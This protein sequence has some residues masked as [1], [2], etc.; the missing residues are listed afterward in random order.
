MTISS[1]AGNGAVNSRGG[2]GK[3]I[4]TQSP[5]E[6]KEE[7]R[8]DISVKRYFWIFVLVA[9]EWYCE[10]GDDRKKISKWRILQEEE[11]HSNGA[12]VVVLRI[13]VVGKIK[14]KLL[15]VV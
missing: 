11:V 12:A 9:M 8:E 2:D 1:I 4:W 6:G 3:V 15:I 14:R 10:E 7:D 5:T 13:V